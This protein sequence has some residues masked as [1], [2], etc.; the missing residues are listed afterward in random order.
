MS[1][2]QHSWGGTCRRFGM[3]LVAFCWLALS[4]SFCWGQSVA[5][6]PLHALYD[7]HDWFGLRDAVQAGGGPIFYRGAIESVFNQIGPAEKDLEA[8]IRGAPHSTDTHEA[9]ALLAQMYFRNG[10]YRE[11]YR[12]LKGMAAEDPHAED[13][14]NMTSLLRVLSAFNQVVVTRKAS[15]L[16]MFMNGSGVYL[17]I[18]LDGHEAHYSLDSGAS[19]SLM[20]ESEAKRLGLE[21]RATTTQMGSVTAQ[22][23]GARIAF[24]KDLVIGGLH[25]QNVAFDVLPDAQEPFVDSPEE[26]RGILGMPVLLA[27]QTLRWEPKG[28]FALGFQPQPK[29]LTI[30]N[31]VFDGMS[32]FTQ[33]GVEGRQYEFSLDTGETRSILYAPFARAFPELLKASGKKESHK[34]TG[35]AGSANYDS[36]VLPS[37][38]LTLGG[39]DTRLA[40]APVLV[41]ESTD[42]SN[43]VFG[44]LGRDLLNQARVIT[45]DFHAMTLR[46][47]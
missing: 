7:A 42:K 26:Q 3:G 4:S 13:V 36:I 25:L 11:A 40:P 33:V 10:L 21:I 38:T 27:M 16:P 12:Q 31:L 6:S 1:G 39:F 17:P 30:A 8:V 46:L 43:L 29:D 23:I 19:P 47:Q 24:V 35:V 45:F 9:R 2:S 20:S 14:K 44:N 28:A 32:P 18:T 34:L 5:P 22:H 15:T 37:V 41:Q